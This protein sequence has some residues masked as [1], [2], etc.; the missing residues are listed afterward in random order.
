MTRKIGKTFPNSRIRVT[1]WKTRVSDW[2]IRVTDSGIGATDWGVGDTN[3]GMGITDSG[4]GIA[5]S[6]IV[7]TDSEVSP[8]IRGG[9]AVLAS[10]KSSDPCSNVVRS[11]QE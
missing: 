11:D 4:I 6:G 9:L 5:H 7:E 10:T 2:R 1:D 3:S 8:A